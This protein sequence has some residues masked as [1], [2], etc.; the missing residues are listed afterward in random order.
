MNESNGKAN[1]AGITPVIVRTLSSTRTVLPSASG[2]PPNRSRQSRSLMMT[3]C[4]A[5]L[6]SSPLRKSRPT[7][8][9][10]PSVVMS[11]ALTYAMLSRSGPLAFATVTMLG[12]IIIAPSDSNTWL[13][14]R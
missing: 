4:A 12:A 14:A 3:G 5:V 7:M 8:G 6:D 11:P 13:C 10:T 9:E 1:P 2:E